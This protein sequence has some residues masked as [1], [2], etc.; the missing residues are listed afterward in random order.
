LLRNILR[1]KK[2]FNNRYNYLHKSNKN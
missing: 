1:N 2:I